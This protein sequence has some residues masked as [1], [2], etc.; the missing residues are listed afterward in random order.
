MSEKLYT[1][2]P[3]K[4]MQKKIFTQIEVLVLAS[5]KTFKIFYNS[6]SKT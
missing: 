2:M 6:K 3:K 4:S 1:Q 5:F